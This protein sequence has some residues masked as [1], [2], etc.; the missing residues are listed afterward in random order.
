MLG[1]T[2]LLFIFA[3][4]NPSRAIEN[5]YSSFKLLIYEKIKFTAIHGYVCS[6][7]IFLC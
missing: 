4:V 3:P 1:F 5:I 7:T 2:D 6:F